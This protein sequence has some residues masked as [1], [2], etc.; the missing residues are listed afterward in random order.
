M[1]LSVAC[2]SAGAGC[3]MRWRPGCW[4]MGPATGG[5]Q[6]S[7][8]GGSLALAHQPSI[9]G[10]CPWCHMCLHSAALVAC[11]LH[12]HLCTTLHIYLQSSTCQTCGWSSSGAMCRRSS[13]RRLRRWCGAARWPPTFCAAWWLTCPGRSSLWRP[14][15]CAPR[16]CRPRW[17]G[18][19]RSLRRSGTFIICGAVASAVGWVS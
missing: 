4:S 16:G 15:R 12:T 1:P 8:A 19:S 17:T 18:A 13:R 6:V 11:S 3:H 9:V 14:A 2:C 10:S 7:Q 5:K